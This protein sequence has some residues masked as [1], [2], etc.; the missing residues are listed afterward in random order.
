MNVGEQLRR[1]GDGLRGAVV[2][3]LSHGSITVPVQNVPA[4][5][6]LEV[7]KELIKD[8]PG[9]QEYKAKPKDAFDKKKG[10]L[11]GHLKGA[12]YDDIPANSRAALEALSDAELQLLSKLDATFVA[13]GLYV[14]VPSPGKLFYK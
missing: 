6:S 13:D 8:A 12:K 3:A 4:A 10:G 5:R 2:R 14:D 11:G 7:V 1:V 9:R